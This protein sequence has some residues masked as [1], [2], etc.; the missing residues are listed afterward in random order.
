MKNY[1]KSFEDV[2]T[3]DRSINKCQMDK[4]STDINLNGDDY[5]DLMR[6]TYH[7]FYRDI[8]DNLVKVSW[9]SSRFCYDGKNR[10]RKRYN[11][12]YLD[13]AFGVFMRHHVGVESRLITRDHA[14]Y[15]ISS[16]F[17]DF[18]P[19]FHVLNPFE[20]KFE[21]PY[22]HITLEY[23]VYVYQMEERMELLA[24]AEEEKMRY[25]EFMDYIINYISSYNEELGEQYY[26][27]T[28]S[29]VYM[30]YVK[31]KK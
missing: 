7:A 14:F 2:F 27:I 13:S 26:E 19:D 17:P 6:E 3:S 24:K 21:Y 5:R 4:V 12:V 22:K 8:F 30:P 10:E 31:V 15:H 28:L 16:Y 9:L 23:L 25:T 29:H 20:K 1:P 11:G 18:F